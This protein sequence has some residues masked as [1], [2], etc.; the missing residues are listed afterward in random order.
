MFGTREMY[1]AETEVIRLRRDLAAFVKYGDVQ[2]AMISFVNPTTRHAGCS[3][4]GG[5]VLT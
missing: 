3:G 4:E 5:E 1:T 2:L